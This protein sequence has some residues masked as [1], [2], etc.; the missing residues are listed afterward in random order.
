MVPKAIFFDLDDTILSFTASSDMCWRQVCAAYG[1][2]NGCITPE[3]LHLAIDEYSH[4]YWQDSERHRLGRQNLPQARRDIVRAVLKNLG[5][6]NSTLAQ[7]IGDAYS[8]VRN[9]AIWLLPG[10]VDTLHYLQQKGIRL[11]LITNGTSVEQRGKIERFELARFFDCIVIEEEFGSGKPEARVYHHTLAQMRVN[12][13]EVW[14]VGDNLEW[15]VWGAQQVGICGIWVD[16]MGKGLPPTSP[17]QPNR[18]IRSVTELV[19]DFDRP[20]KP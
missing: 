5:V 4:W 14:M 19:E 18:I 15:D 20:S 6:D 12:A 9:Q 13:T 11:A 10:A 3:A 8:A 17:I 2:V 1:P 16:F 7:Q